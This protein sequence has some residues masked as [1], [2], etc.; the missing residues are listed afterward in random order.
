MKILIDER[1]I[2][3][4]ILEYEA[5]RTYTECEEYIRQWA[6]TALERLLDIVGTAD[7]ESE[8]KESCNVD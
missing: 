7:I 8:R 5:Q 3:S 2:K 1:V 6:V 4:L